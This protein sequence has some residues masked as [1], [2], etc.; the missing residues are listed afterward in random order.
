MSMLIAN[1]FRKERD[2][3]IKGRVIRK[4]KQTKE[5]VD[6]PRD[7]ARKAMLPG[8]RVSKGGKVY[9]ETRASRSDNQGSNL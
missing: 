1:A 3:F 5:R 8:K 9:W 7:E 6:L 2:L 4:L